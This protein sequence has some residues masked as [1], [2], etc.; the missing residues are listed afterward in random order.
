MKKIISTM[1][2]AALSFA[3]AGSANAA[4]YTASYGT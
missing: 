2:A 3:A 4:L 1:F